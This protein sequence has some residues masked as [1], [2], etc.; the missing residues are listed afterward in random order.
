MKQGLPA[1]RKDGIAWGIARGVVAAM[2]MTGMRQVTTGL[3]LVEQTPPDAVFKQRAPG[4]LVRMP[5]LAF[6][7]ARRETCSHRACPLVLR[8]GRRRRLRPAPAPGVP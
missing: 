8:C 2:A 3:G 1:G 6:F 5:R 4:V 7:V